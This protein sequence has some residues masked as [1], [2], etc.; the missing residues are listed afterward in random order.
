MTNRRPWFANKER[1]A[2]FD[3]TIRFLSVPSNSVN[4][5]RSVSQYTAVNA[6]QRQ[7]FNDTNLATQ[8]MV[9]FNAR[10]YIR[11]I[12]G[13]VTSFNPH[14]SIGMLR[15]LFLSVCQTSFVCPQTFL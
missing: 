12:I 10:D 8:A 2:L 3:L 1:F 7:S 5:K 15:I 4:V 13:Y 14:M 6:P 11:L 9:A